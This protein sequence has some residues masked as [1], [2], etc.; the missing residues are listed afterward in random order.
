MTSDEAPHESVDGESAPSAEQEPSAPRPRRRRHWILWLVLAFIVAPLALLALWTTITLSYTY[1]RGNRAGYV[2]KF[3]QKG[4]LCKTWEGELAMV[5]VPGA[6]QERWDF[7]VRND[8]I[9]QVL[10]RDMG[11]QVSLS[12]E[13]HKGVPLSCFGE[14][15]YFVTGVRVVSH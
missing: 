5:N 1:S 6:L 12:Y 2:Q 11:S 14:T 10:L 13:Q 4:W 7:S 15:E 9:A 8:S 3:S